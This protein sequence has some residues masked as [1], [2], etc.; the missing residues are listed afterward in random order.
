MET[1][2]KRGWDIYREKQTDKHR[3]RLRGTEREEGEKR[4]VGT[5]GL[6]SGIGRDMRK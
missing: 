4:E 1:S 5:R 3:R 6:E 2:E